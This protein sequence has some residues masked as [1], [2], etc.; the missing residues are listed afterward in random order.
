MRWFLLLGL[1]VGCSGPEAPL[2]EHKTAAAAPDDYDAMYFVLVDRFA[3]G[4][5]TND[6]AIDLSDPEDRKNKGPP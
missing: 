2:A 4:N 1:L 3:N 6:G 5:P